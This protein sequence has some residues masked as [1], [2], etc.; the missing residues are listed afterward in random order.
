MKRLLTIILLAIT[1]F[2][3]GQDIEI[4]ASQIKYRQNNEGSLTEWSSWNKTNFNIVIYGNELKIIAYTN[5]KD[6]YTITESKPTQFIDDSIIQDY[7]CIDQNGKR[8]T[9][10]IVKSRV[11]NLVLF[12]LKYSN[13]EYICSG[14]IS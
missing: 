13:W 6:I 4:K 10:T 14:T 2:C 7:Y 12:N 9:I 1:I 5:P 3:F 11:K 8:C